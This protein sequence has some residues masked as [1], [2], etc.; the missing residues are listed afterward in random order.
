MQAVPPKL[1]KHTSPAEAILGLLTAGYVVW[2]LVYVVYCFSNTVSLRPGT[3]SS[4]LHFVLPSLIIAGPLCV[5]AGLIC[6]GILR[7]GRSILA[8]RRHRVRSSFYLCFCIVGIGPLIA[9][10]FKIPGIV[11]AVFGTWQ[12][13]AMTPLVVGAVYLIILGFV[14]VVLLVGKPKA[15]GARFYKLRR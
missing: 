12:P 11:K 9:I 10:Q 15:P 6:V 1:H 2:T 14:K 4:F 3:Y 13:N 5:W 7:F 8:E